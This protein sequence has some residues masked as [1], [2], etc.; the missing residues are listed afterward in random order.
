MKESRAKMKAS[1]A[2]FE[3]ASELFNDLEETRQQ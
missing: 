3:T 1:K 2:R